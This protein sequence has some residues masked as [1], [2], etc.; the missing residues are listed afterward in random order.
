MKG[1]G[2][3]RS[4]CPLEVSLD[5]GRDQHGRRVRG[6][7]ANGPL[8]WFDSFTMNGKNGA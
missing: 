5:I 1:S 8:M 4:P 2:Q 7:K 3:Q 6:T